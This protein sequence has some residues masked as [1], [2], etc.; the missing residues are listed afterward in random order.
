[1]SNRWW[2][3]GVL[4][5]HFNPP[6]SLNGKSYVVE[7]CTTND[8]HYSQN[9][10]K[11]ASVAQ[12]EIVYSCPYYVAETKPSKMANLTGQNTVELDS[13]VLCGDDTASPALA[14]GSISKEFVPISRL[15]LASGMQAT[16]ISSGIGGNVVVVGEHG[17][18]TLSEA[19]VIG[20]V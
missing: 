18:T 7:V 2:L 13:R 6:S 12:K 14:S 8:G 20:R 1:M 19:E 4:K 16:G 17:V 10:F 15:S 9:C 5:G 11:D 3:S